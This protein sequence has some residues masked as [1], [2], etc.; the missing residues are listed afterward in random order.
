MLQECGCS[1]SHML[2]VVRM[3]L[4]ITWRQSKYTVI[5]ITVFSHLCH[6]V[7][8]EN[9][10]HDAL[11]PTIQKN[12]NPQCQPQGSHCLAS[13]WLLVTTGDRNWRPGHTCLLEDPLVA[14]IWRLMEQVQSVCVSVCVCVGEGVCILLKSFL[15]SNVISYVCIL[16]LCTNSFFFISVSLGKH[17][18]NS[19]SVSGE[20]IPVIQMYRKYGRPET[21]NKKT[22]VH[23]SMSW[24]YARQNSEICENLS[25]ELKS[26]V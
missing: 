10:I 9:I 22:A 11:D 25:P 18:N 15:V 23:L 20:R 4:S 19:W 7:Q 16:A 6:S 12:P 5:S 1:Y 21:V 8:K 2:T 26:F 24:V 17:S 3:R 14:E 13:F